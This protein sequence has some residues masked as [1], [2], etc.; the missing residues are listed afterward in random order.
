[1]GS[2]THLVPLEGKPLAQHAVDALAASD[3]EEIVVVTGHDA[4]AVEAA[5]ALPPRGRFVR[6][7]DHRDGQAT[8]LAAALHELAD[9]SEAAVVLMADQPRVPAAVV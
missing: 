4:D 7:P 9:D 8:S 6:N 1:F 2:S 3:V 5:I